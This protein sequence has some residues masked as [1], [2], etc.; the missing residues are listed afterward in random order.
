MKIEMSDWLLFFFAHLNIN[1]IIL[2]SVVH[3]WLKVASIAKKNKM[4]QTHIS[5]FFFSTCGY[6]HFSQLIST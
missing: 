4:Q 2:S 1:N 6:K 3:A 5:G